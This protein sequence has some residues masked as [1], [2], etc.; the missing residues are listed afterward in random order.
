[1][2]SMPAFG[3]HQSKSATNYK[4][5]NANSPTN[6]LKVMFSEKL[7]MNPVSSVLPSLTHTFKSSQQFGNEQMIDQPLTAK[8]R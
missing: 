4:T 1:M 2:S 8:N 7:A 6:Q 3:V 5:I